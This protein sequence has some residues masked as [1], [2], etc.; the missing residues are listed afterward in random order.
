MSI[1]LMSL[2]W[3]LSQVN[4]EINR[5]DKF[6]L[7]ALADHA[8]DDGECYPSLSRIQKKCFF[9]RQGVLNSMGRIIKI[10]YVSKNKRKRENGSNTSNLYRLHEDLFSFKIEEA[11]LLN[12]LAK[13][14]N[15]VI[16][17]IVYEIDKGSLSDRLE[18]VHEV[19]KGSLRDRQLYEPSINHHCESSFN[20]SLERAQKSKNYLDF[21]KALIEYCP[22]FDFS[23]AGK[24]G[25]SSE[26][27]GFELQNGLL[28]DKMLSRP[29]SMEEIN[30]IWEYIFS[31][32]FE[33]IKVLSEQ[34]QLF[35]KRI[36]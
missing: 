20:L 8:N 17:E 14:K 33:F 13:H 4:S 35:E 15:T 7:L 27:L 16:A 29:M 31:I 19:D 36:S 23:L 18:V 12:D 21:R 1:K 34:K 6:L 10:G 32:R 24:I 22:T 25:Y 2:V 9:S 3:E 30:K 26:H 5:D 28:K 11:K